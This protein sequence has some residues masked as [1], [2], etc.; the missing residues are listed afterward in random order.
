[1]LVKILPEYAHDRQLVASGL[2]KNRDNVFQ[3]AIR[4]CG[5]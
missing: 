1:M 5:D 4:L 2:L 3:I